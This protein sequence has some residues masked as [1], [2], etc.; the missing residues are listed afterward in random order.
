MLAVNEVETRAGGRSSRQSLSLRVYLAT[1]LDIHHPTTVR[2]HGPRCIL[3]HVHSGY[4]ISLVLGVTRALFASMNWNASL[5]IAVHLSRWWKEDETK[6]KIKTGRKKEIKE[7]AFLAW[8]H[9]DDDRRWHLIKTEE[10]K[11]RKTP[12]FFVRTAVASIHDNGWHFQVPQKR[13]MADTRRQQ[14]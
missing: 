3:L 10:R 13:K 12:N 9:D 7:T 14:Q 8:K 5:S 2:M 4:T 11:K 1:T 6:Q